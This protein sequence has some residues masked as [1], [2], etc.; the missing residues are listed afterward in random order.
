MTST[1]EPSSGPVVRIAYLRAK[2]GQREALLAAARAN[3]EDAVAA[4]ALSA[5]VCSEPDSPEDV[6]V[7]SRWASL[8]AVQDF[9]SWHES[10]AHERL[11]DHAEGRPRAVHYPVHSSAGVPRRS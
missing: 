11:G 9:L 8:T 7:I 10:H 1:Q 2:A 6:L 4:G 3:T 5:E